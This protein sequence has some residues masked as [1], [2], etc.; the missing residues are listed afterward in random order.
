MKLFS[1][2]ILPVHRLKVTLIFVGISALL[3]DLVLAQ[4]T[5]PIERLQITGPL[6]L[7]KAVRTGLRENLLIRAAQSD[8]RAASADT[9]AA[10]SMTRLQISANTFL[11]HGDTSNILSSSPG[12]Q[13]TNLYAVPS[14]LFADQNLTL[15][16]PLYTGGRLGS[17]VRSAA[18]RE[19]AALADSETVHIETT[20]QI[21]ETYYRVLLAGEIVSAAQARVA[22]DTALLANTRVQVD[23][24]KSIEASL[25]RV[26]AELADAQRMLTTAMNDK[27]KLLLDFKMIIGVRLDSDITLSDTLAFV[28]P[29]GDLST[30]LK[31]AGKNRPRIESGT[32]QSSVDR[33][34]DRGC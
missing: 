23:V 28:P 6:T 20:L 19:H 25:L 4:K 9:R 34:P 22:A 15:M 1:F 16:V 29:P 32:Q 21:R 31:E 8:V 12:V 13:P 30:S 27:A 14:R 5:I 26:Q 7:E 10:R 33:G 11:T 24:G 17:L 18:E 2:Q 3:P